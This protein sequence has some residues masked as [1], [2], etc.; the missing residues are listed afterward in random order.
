M[1]KYNVSYKTIKA[2][3]RSPKI[4]GPGEMGKNKEI[5]IAEDEPKIKRMMNIMG[6]MRE[7]IF[8]AF[9][10]ET[11][12]EENLKTKDSWSLYFVWRNMREERERYK[13]ER[14]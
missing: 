10:F 8:K 9:L 7:K 1:K 3:I 12:K 6:P 4:L 11:K 2:G 13:T 14:I 5:A